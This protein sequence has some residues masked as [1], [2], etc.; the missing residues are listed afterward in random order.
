MILKYHWYHVGTNKHYTARYSLCKD[1]HQKDSAV[2]S[3]TKKVNSMTSLLVIMKI[4]VYNWF[5]SILHIT[6][7]NL[8]IIF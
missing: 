8:L 2:I 5:I 7:I 1:F 4:Y 6:V 3:L